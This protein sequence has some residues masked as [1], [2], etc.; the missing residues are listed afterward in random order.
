MPALTS[1]LVCGETVPTPKLPE[2]VAVPEI[3]GVVIVGDV[4]KTNAPLP[5][6]PVTAAARFALVGVSRNV[7]TFVPSVGSCDVRANVPLA[8]GNSMLLSS[9][10]N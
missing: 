9:V 1:N 6:S 8:L 3:V 10:A 5:V 7:A 2:T 4:P